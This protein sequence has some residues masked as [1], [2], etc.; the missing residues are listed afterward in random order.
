MSD[1]MLRHTEAAEF[2]GISP[3]TLYKYT[4]KKLIPHFRSAAGRLT[5]FKREDLIAWQQKHRISSS[6]EISELAS[7]HLNS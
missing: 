2:L 1:K 5:Y 7:K 4:S 3:A 6:D